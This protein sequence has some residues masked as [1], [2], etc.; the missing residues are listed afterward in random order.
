[1]NST[2]HINGLNLNIS[3]HTLLVW[4]LIGLVAGYI[5]GKLMRGAGFGPILDIV[6]GIVGALIGGFI[7]IHLGYAGSG[8][9]FY[10]VFVAV[11]GAV[12]LTFLLRLVTGGRS[13]RF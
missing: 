5:T 9:F 11:I 8:G 3:S 6:V 13:G 2:N 7:M 1:M 12:L 4:I 10:T